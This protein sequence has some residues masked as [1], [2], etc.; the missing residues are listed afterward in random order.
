MISCRW[1]TVK[2]FYCLVAA[3]I[4]A[5]SK[6]NLVPLHLWNHNIQKKFIYAHFLTMPCSPVHISMDSIYWGSPGVKSK[7]RKATA[8]W[9][10]AR[11]KCLKLGSGLGLRFALLAR[12]E[13]KAV[14]IFW[15]CWWRYF[16]VNITLVSPNSK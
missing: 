7:T 12:V 8:P 15:R 4:T 14:N 6:L 3:G 9:I 2:K 13:D 11:G 16:N 1:R 10:G 5:E